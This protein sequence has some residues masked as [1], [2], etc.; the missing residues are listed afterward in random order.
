[1]LS[2]QLADL[3]ELFAAQGSP[4]MPSSFRSRARF[5]MLS[6]GSIVRSAE[7]V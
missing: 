2:A 3:D 1:M 5:S 4:G 6:L 7:A